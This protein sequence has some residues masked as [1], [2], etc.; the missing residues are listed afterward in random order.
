MGPKRARSDPNTTLCR[1]LL[2]LAVAV[3][4]GGWARPTTAK[5]NACAS[6][7]KPHKYK[8]SDSHKDNS[9]TECHTDAGKEA[10]VK[11]L[12]PKLPP[13]AKKLKKVSCGGCHE[14]VIKKLTASIHGHVYKSAGEMCA[15]CHGFHPAKVMDRQNT[16]KVCG[17]CHEDK[18]FTLKYFSAKKHPIKTYLKSTHGKALIHGNKKAPGCTNC[19]GHHEIFK[20]IDPR[21]KINKLNIS[22]TCG[23]CHKKVL[24]IF[25]ESIHGQAFRKGDQNAP[26]CTSCHGEHYILSHKDKGSLVAKAA[27]AKFTCVQCHNS[28]RFIN[29]YQVSRDK[30]GSYKKSYHGL[31]AETG[32]ITA[33]NCVSCHG[34]HNIYPTTDKRSLVHKENLLK[35]CQSCHKKATEAFVRGKIHGSVLANDLEDKVKA[36]VQKIYVWLI[37]GFILFALFHN[38][39]DYVYR[40]RRKV[41]KHAGAEHFTERFP[42]VARIVHFLLLSTF[43]VLVYTGFSLRYEWLRISTNA[44]RGLIHRYAAVLFMIVC[45]AHVVHAFATAKGRKF[46]SAMIP[47]VSDVT[48]FFRLMGIYLGLVK[49]KVTLSE[50]SYVEKLEYLALIWGSIVMAVTGVVMWFPELTGRLSGIPRWGIDVAALIHFLE[51][52][53]A[54]VA[55]ILWHLYHVQFKDG[56]GGNVSWITGK[57]TDSE[58]REEKEYPPVS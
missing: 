13:H 58:M 6:C 32:D 52:I 49:R 2:M 25:D 35:T 36:W 8:L 46:L 11:P 57:L 53:L 24:K 40:V 30:L 7:H 33:A 4:I 12:D 42:M 51:A 44:T 10:A 15:K 38:L 45:F 43:F 31:A 37:V 3:S 48:Q 16:F 28:Q 27:I 20:P 39:L 54:T 19:H 9:C 50:F 34:T 18:E 5:V 21:S 1:Y 23:S 22:K 17:K 47:R 56:P 14:K 29:E 41:R 55:I 26:V